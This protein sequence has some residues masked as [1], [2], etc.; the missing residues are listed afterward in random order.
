MATPSKLFVLQMQDLL[1]LGEESR[2]NR[3]GTL[4]GNWD[5]RMRPG[6][7]DAKLARR[8]HKLTEL[9]RRL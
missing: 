9:Y 1:E 6:A 2:I 5:W 4:G 3:P 8:L 7:A